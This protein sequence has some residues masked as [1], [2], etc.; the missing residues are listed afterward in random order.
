MWFSYD[1]LNHVSCVEG[2][3]EKT[4]NNVV[5]YYIGFDEP[6][7]HY[8]KAGSTTFTKA[9]ME[10]NDERHG[11]KYKYVLEDTSPNAQI[12]FSGDN[13]KIDNNDGNYYTANV[14]LNYYFTKGQRNE[15]Q[16]ADLKMTNGS[17]QTVDIKN[18]GE[19]KYYALSTKTGNGYNVETW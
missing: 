7:L 14:G 16:V 3:K 18:G 8:K 5:V 13:G 11:Y 1:S 10:E 17:D 9:K 15:L 12:Y 19:V 4:T 2:V 6:T